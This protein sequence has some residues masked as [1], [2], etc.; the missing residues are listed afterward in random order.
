MKSRRILKIGSL[1]LLVAVF[2][3]SIFSIFRS[4][5]T[6]VPLR[7]AKVSD[8][9]Q[10]AVRQS[11]APSTFSIPGRLI[12]KA[13]PRVNVLD[14]LTEKKIG[15][16]G[17]QLWTTLWITRIGRGQGTDDAFRGQLEVA[18]ESPGLSADLLIEL[19]KC[20]RFIEPLGPA[21]TVFRA[22][23]RQAALELRAD[24]S[25]PEHRLGLVTALAEIRY[26]LWQMQDLAGI[27]AAAT[28]EI[29]WRKKDYSPE[30]FDACLWFT[31]SSR[32]LGRMTDAV[33]MAAALSDDFDGGKYSGVKVSKRRELDHLR[34]LALADSSPREALVFLD[35]AS[36]HPE[37]AF[38]KRAS[39]E[40]L[41]LAAKGG[42][43]SKQIQDYAKRARTIHAFSP[44][45][46]A[47]LNYREASAIESLETQK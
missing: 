4:S 35:L 14:R 47:D 21:A 46:L 40:W 41:M 16:L 43:T 27:L 29:E 13:S 42:A 30:Y 36:S 3:G 1:G 9:A 26:P 11:V 33:R 20:V 17:L 25:T 7:P 22:A 10:P 24:V 2:I 5:G 8:R 32:A 39:I 12:D 34:G 31:D 18:L 19:G 15:S 44:D 28:L 6:G 38:S 23:I 45:E 37:E